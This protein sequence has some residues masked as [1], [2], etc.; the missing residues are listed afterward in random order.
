M[1]IETSPSR[2]PKNRPPS[3]GEIGG[4]DDPWTLPNSRWNV[5]WL[6]LDGLFFALG[7]NFL[8]PVAILP[9]FVARLTPID[10]LA[11]SFTAI[12]QIGL[13]LPQFAASRWA[14]R[15]ALTGRR[16]WL[17]SGV[18]LIGRIP[19]AV[20]IGVIVIY[21]DSRPELA[22]AAVMIGFALFRLFEGMGVPAY[23][24]L[25]GTVVHPRLRARYFAWQQAATALG[26][27]VAGLAARQVLGAF[28][29]PWNFAAS[30]SIGLALAILVTIVFLQ[31]REPAPG[32]AARALGLD[33]G[34]PQE[35]W[36]QTIR[37]I[38]A[39]D[40]TFRRLVV[41]RALI[42]IAGMAPA[43]YAVSAVRR[44]DA[45]DADAATFGL[46]TLASQLFGTIVW[47]EVTAR[48]RR[49]WFLVAGPILGAVGATGALI[50]GSI[51][52]LYPTFVAAGAAFAAQLMCDM[53]IPIQLAERAARPRGRYVA[54]YSTL[55]IPFSIAAPVIGG[56]LAGSAGFVA[57]DLTGIGAYI[58][59]T[60]TGVSFVRLLH[61]GR[62]TTAA[63]A[64]A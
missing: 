38:W 13:A 19:I 41:A 9:V 26:G 63:V 60:F 47:G 6:V 51:E 53:S 50:A 21:G 55:I 4:L 42:G 5:A 25:V 3:D 58:V 52:T 37:S 7:F 44:L 11:G 22:V 17:K 10:L 59:A 35:A 32:G 64:S 49:P 36:W 14:E 43:Y 18:N 1:T 45:T 15:A 27:L 30:F 20:A 31:V 23:Y 56:L 39:T 16:K 46:L 33:P 28:P 40:A 12:D 48:T 8:S 34:T 2:H 62:T 24:D 61:R 57:V 29:F 54:A